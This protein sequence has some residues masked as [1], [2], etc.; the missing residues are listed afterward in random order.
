MTHINKPNDSEVD[1]YTY[2][3]E[4][5]ESLG[6]NIKNPAKVSVGEVY[7][8]NEALSN[9]DIKSCLN[10]NRPEAIVKVSDNIFWIIESKRTKDEI[11]KAL[12]EAKNQYAKK[13]NKS[14]SISAPLVSGVAGNLT[15]GFLVETQIL[16]DGQWK[17]ILFNGRKKRTL[18]SRPQAKYIIK[19]KNIDYKEFPDI[20]QQKYISAGV[21][22]NEILH[23]SGIN[24]NKRARFIAALILSTSTGE[25]VDFVKENTKTLIR[26]INNLIQQKLDEVGKSNFYDF[27]KL[28]LP[29]SQENHHKYREAIIQTYNK[30]DT[31]EIRNSMDSGSDVLGEF[32]TTFLKYGNGAKEIGIVLTPRHITK[33]AVEVCDINYKDIVLDPA[34]GTGG[35]LVSSLD[36]VR[37]ESTGE[38][39]E[40]FKKYGLFGIEQD[41]E[42][43]ALALVN[44]IFRGDGRH[45]MREG[46]CFNNN[47]TNK[48]E[49][50]NQTA[51]FE[52]R[53]GINN[54]RPAITKVLMNPP[55]SLKKEDEK[56]SKFIDYALDQLKDKGILFAITPVS[57][58]TEGK[59]GSKWR[60]KLLEENTI[61]SVVTFPDIF[62][63]VSII[64][65]GIFIKKGVPHDFENQNVY[66]ARINDD[67]FTK[68]KGKRVFNDSVENDLDK[69]KKELV[70]FIKDE[71]ISIDNVPEFKKVAKLDKDDET[72][73][74]AP[75]AYLDTKVLTRKEI[76][77][78]VEEMIRESVAFRIRYNKKFK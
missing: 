75:E 39:F 18:L 71:N 29:P 66:F 23:N 20:P 33:F 14:L 16:K 5:L 9:I 65:V 44:M 21:E 57:V 10:R 38:R 74:L 30:L 70:A 6:W 11:N 4:E 17:T 26:D 52:S 15:D 63:P 69:I 2:I 58:M 25:R 48:T 32:Y 41:D 13:I 54:T 12:D 36:K 76:E 60:K 50:G 62:Y 46:N 28:E 35:F 37:R 78:G 43:V 56:E 67:G 53:D 64:T 7:K 42:V 1:A 59:S 3:K 49:G 55:F 51:Q 31:L 40:N 45:N 24:K 47:I 73:E 61:L 77:D 8:Q 34:C 68:R 27:I 19:T 72:H 22:I